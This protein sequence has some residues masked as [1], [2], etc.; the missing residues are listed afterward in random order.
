MFRKSYEYHLLVIISFTSERAQES[1]VTFILTMNEPTV[2][3][4]EGVNAG[5]RKRTATHSASLK[6]NLAAKVRNHRIDYK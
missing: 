5:R 6:V 2:N 1:T 3:G 4:R